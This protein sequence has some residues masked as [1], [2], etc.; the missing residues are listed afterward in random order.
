MTEAQI[1]V[2]M[3]DI[4][5]GRT[6]LTIAHRLSTIMGADKIL[7]LS[8]GSLVEAGSHND[9][10]K[11]ENGIYKSLWDQQQQ[12]ASLRKNLE[13][14]TNLKI[15]LDE[16]LTSVGSERRDSHED[17]IQDQQ[18]LLPS[19]AS[20]PPPMD[21]NKKLS[22]LFPSQNDC[23]T[24]GNTRDTNQANSYMP[25]PGDDNEDGSTNAGFENEMI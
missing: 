25:I 16:D 14:V 23:I 21:V 10:L 3:D 8:K 17:G 7:V 24:F 1:L 15:D 6:C 4:A 2:A 20:E 22:G 9:L 5:K 13:V 18:R 11:I 12:I 19:V